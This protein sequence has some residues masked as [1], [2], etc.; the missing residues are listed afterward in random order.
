MR[1][2]RSLGLVI[3]TELVVF[4]LLWAMVS[5]GSALAH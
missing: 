3:A 2:F 1:M 4:S 5:L